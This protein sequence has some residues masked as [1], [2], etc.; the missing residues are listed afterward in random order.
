[1]A[2]KRA[3]RE[4]PP[5][6][7]EVEDDL[8]SVLEMRADGIEARLEAAE[9]EAAANLDLALRS[10]A[11][12]DNYRKRVARD[13]ADSVALACRRIVE[14]LLPMLDGLEKAI[15]HAIAGD[16][17]EHLLTGVE[18]V[19]AQVLDVFAKEGVEVIDPFGQPFDPTA[20]QAIQQREDLE[21]PDATVIEVFQKGYVMAGRVVRPAMVV[22]SL[23]GKAR[24]L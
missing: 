13:Q 12:F 3:E 2:G 19:R 10:Q 22:V 14:E 5:V 20:H 6:D 4:T 18:M 24:H 21:V 15:D 8:G 11:E 23:G 7:P 17:S 16:D 9:A 1:M